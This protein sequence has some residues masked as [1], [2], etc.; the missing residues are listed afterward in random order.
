MTDDD[1]CFLPAHELAAMIA[2]RRVSPVEI[3]RAVLA[4]I[5]AHEPR[6]RAFATLLAEPAMAAARRAE[7]AVA[8]GATLGPL[9]GVPVTI[10]DLWPRAASRPSA[11]AASSQA[12][13]RTRTRRWSR[14]CAAP[15][16]S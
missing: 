1:L 15:A 3:M 16:P 13:S 10:K 8:S 2:A 5:D 6:V 11:A 7:A 14:G 4:R 9:H 12:L